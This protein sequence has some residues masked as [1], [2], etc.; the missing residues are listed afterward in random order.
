MQI[1]SCKITSSFLS[2]MDASQFVSVRM[3][4]SVQCWLS[5]ARTRTYTVTR[6]FKKPLSTSTLQ[7]EG[8]EPIFMFSFNSFNQVDRRILL[9]FSCL[10]LTLSSNLPSKMIVGCLSQHFTA[11]LSLYEKCFLQYYTAVN[12]KYYKNHVNSFIY[13]EEMIYWCSCYGHIKKV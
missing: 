10:T 11:T 3:L 9:C 5:D 1:Q 4:I 13:P 7:H 12:L 2:W 8:T 6:T